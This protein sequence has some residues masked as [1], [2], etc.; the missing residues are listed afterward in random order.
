MLQTNCRVRS[1]VN[2]RGVQ[3]FCEAVVSFGARRSQLAFV[4][5]DNQ[6]RASGG[7]PF[8]VEPV[9]SRDF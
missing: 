2:T 6:C 4:N 5:A 9:T 8:L 1:Q 3:T 7:P